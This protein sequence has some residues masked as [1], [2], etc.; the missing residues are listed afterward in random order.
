M[1][2]KAA[3]PI[4]S[5]PDNRKLLKHAIA[6]TVAVAK[7]K[8]IDLSD[9][10][11]TK[12]GDFYGGIPPDTK[13]SMLMDLENGRRIELNW[14]SGA[15]AQFGD[16]LGVPTPTHHAICGALRLAAEGRSV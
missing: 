1:L 15:V 11:V 6:E 7:V 2:R 10:Y 5:D 16:E 4:M 8:G 9:D 14:L 13:S 3:R 12:H